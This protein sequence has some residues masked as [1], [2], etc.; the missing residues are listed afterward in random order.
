MRMRYRWTLLLAG[1]LLLPTAA[2]AQTD[3]PPTLFT[4]I[5]S[6][7]PY[8]GAGVYTG[9]T[10]LFWKTNRPLRSQT[11]AVR[12]FIDLDGAITNGVG[13]FVGNGQ[14]ALDVSDLYG[15]GVWQ[16]GWDFRF[17]Y[18][19]ENGIAVEFGWRHLVQARYTAI[20]TILPPDFN[21]GARFENTFLTAF[22]NNFTP[23][24][25]GSVLNVPQGTSATTFGIWNAA[26]YMSIQY[27][28]R[29]DTYEINARLPVWQTY[30]YRI[31]GLFGPR[32]AWAFD[33]FSWRTVDTNV[34]GEAS[35]ETTANYTNTISNRMYGFH[36]GFGNDWYCGSTPIGAFSFVCD[37]EGGLYLDL[38]KAKAAWER[39][40]RAVSVSRARRFANVSPAFEAR[41]GFRWYPWEAI[42]MELGYEFQ[43]YFNTIS[44]HHPVDF[45]MGSVDPAYNNQFMRHFHGLRVGIGFVF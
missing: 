22:V 7:Q 43:A 13:N 12:G 15:P 42:S 29:F 14:P 40:D 5:L 32:I 36:A 11:I 37:V 39:G 8:D 6:H 26:S 23:D 28:Q 33:R 27:E 17:G 24:W 44:S 41:L 30:D 34:T 31:Y 19:W 20:A 45:N 4:G 9:W 16:P 2:P 1:L 10:F 18:R 38:V 25:A 21:T 35:G 3:V